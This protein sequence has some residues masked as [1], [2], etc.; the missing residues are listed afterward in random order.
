MTDGRTKPANGEVLDLIAVVVASDT[1]GRADDDPMRHTPVHRKILDLCRRPV[2][3]ADIAADAALPTG[4]VRMLLADLIFQGAI[5]VL[6]D[7]SFAQRPGNALLREIL[8]G[9]RTL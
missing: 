1:T 9:L 8:D 5:T 2:T 7:R 6:R 3:V 4:V